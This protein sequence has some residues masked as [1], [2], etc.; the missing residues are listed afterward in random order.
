METRLVGFKQMKDVCLHAAMAKNRR[1][2]K[3]GYSPCTLV[4][5]V[6]ERLIAS[7]LNHYLEEPDDV[8]ITAATEEREYRTSMEIRKAAMKAVVELDHSEKWAQ[9]IKFLSRNEPPTF[10]VPG[11]QCFFYSA[12]ERKNRKGRQSRSTAGNWHGPAWL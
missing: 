2:G 6:D 4:F 8:A 3:T 10:F 12:A 5:G 11:S 9:A 7:G 1:P